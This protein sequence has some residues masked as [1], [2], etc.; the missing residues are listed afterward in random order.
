M[1]DK[2]CLLNG[3]AHRVANG[4]AGLAQFFHHQGKGEGIGADAAVFLAEGQ[5]QKANL[6]HFLVDIMRKFL[7]LV[8]FHRSGGDD[9]FGKLL[10][11]FLEHFLFFIQHVGTVLSSHN[12]RQSI[13]L[14]VQFVFV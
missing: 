12:V 9:F 8:D 13:F 2:L 14:L 5:A 3:H 11:R 7:R 1:A 10:G 6:S 4:G